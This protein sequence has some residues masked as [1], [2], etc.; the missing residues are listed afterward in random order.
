M[1]I[2]SVR[3]IIWWVDKAVDREEVRQE[4][5]NRFKDGPVRDAILSAEIMVDFSSHEVV[6]VFQKP[7]EIENQDEIENNIIKPPCLMCG[8]TDYE[9]YLHH[10]RMKFHEGN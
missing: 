3:T 10:H 2:T 9:G 8:S 7:I 4:L 5:A 6:A 1:T